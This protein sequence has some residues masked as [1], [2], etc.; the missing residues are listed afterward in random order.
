MIVIHFSWPNLMFSTSVLAMVPLRVVFVTWNAPFE[1]YQYHQY[2]KIRLCIEE[3]LNF[4]TRMKMGARI[5]TRAGKQFSGLYVSRKIV[6]H[7]GRANR[8]E[9]IIG[10]ISRPIRVPSPVN[11][12]T[13]EVGMFLRRAIQTDRVAPGGERW[14]STHPPPWLFPNV[15]MLQMNLI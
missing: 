1:N 5:N 11:S 13:A 12:R 6:R 8:Q 10:V 4:L 2:E 9:V 3:S 15:G 14:R 7:G